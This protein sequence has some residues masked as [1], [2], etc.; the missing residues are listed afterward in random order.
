MSIE[1]DGV[2]SIDWLMGL[3][4]DQLACREHSSL[5]IMYYHISYQEAQDDGDDELISEKK[6]KKKL[7]AAKTDRIVSTCYSG[8]NW[9]YCFLF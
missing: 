7:P 3:D 5:A 9:S 2:Q 8:F 6:T 4:V 1:W